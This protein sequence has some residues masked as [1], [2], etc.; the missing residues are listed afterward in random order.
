MKNNRGNIT[1]FKVHNDI[2]HSLETI[3]VLG[4]LSSFRYLSKL[5]KTDKMNYF[6]LLIAVLPSVGKGRVNSYIQYTNI[7]LNCSDYFL[8]KEIFCKVLI[9]K[10]FRQFISFL[11]FFQ[12]EVW[13]TKKRLKW[14]VLSLK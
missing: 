8:M 4:E 7:G 1:D 12:S 2:V 13:K 3:N 11:N 9:R 14:P 10:A 6:V 5:Y